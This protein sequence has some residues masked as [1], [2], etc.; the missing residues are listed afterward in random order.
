MRQGVFRYLLAAVLIGLGVLLILENIGINTLN[1]KSA[2]LNLYPVLFI[3]YGLKTFIDRIRLRR[4]NWMFGSFVL[5][6]GILL[7]FDRFGV[8]AFAFKDILKLWPL[9]I[10]YL[11]FFFIRPKRAHVASSGKKGKHGFYYGP[12]DYTKHYDNGSYHKYARDKADYYKTYYKD[13]YRDVVYNATGEREANPSDADEKTA[14][15]HEFNPDGTRQSDSDGQENTGDNKRA[16][17][18]KKNGD[19]AYTS[20]KKD[21]SS[22]SKRSFFSVGDFEY[23]REN[24]KVEPMHLNKLAGD[25]YFD[26]T[27]AFIPESK[28][29]ISISSLA[30]DVRILIPEN[31]AFRVEADVKA[32]DINVLHEVVEGLNRSLFFETDDYNDAT[33]KLDFTLR[34]KAGSI[35]IDHV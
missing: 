15:Y 6:F 22:S 1:V 11:G 14:G 35:R 32:G 8:F 9:L 16:K 12:Y 31:I 7:M 23:S 5:I 24:W 28:I 18:T 34:L 4:L 27:K 29:P 25:F 20:G 3:V 13:K 2:W 10:I 26:F 30:G 33:K 19:H 17:G 21:T